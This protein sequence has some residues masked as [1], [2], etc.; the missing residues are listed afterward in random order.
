[1]TNQNCIH[2]EIKSRL[3]LVNVFYHLVFTTYYQG[4]QMRLRWVWHVR[5]ERKNAYRV[6]VG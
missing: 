2:E 1:M 5:G 3:K 6:V 4:D